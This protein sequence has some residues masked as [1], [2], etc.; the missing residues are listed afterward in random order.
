M[1]EA[2]RK[3]NKLRPASRLIWGLVRNWTED[4][5]FPALLRVVLGKAG[6]KNG[7]EFSSEK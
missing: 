4:F 7:F 6:I 3:L 1:K 5:R 2:L